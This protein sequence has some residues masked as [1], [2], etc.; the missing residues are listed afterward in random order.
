MFSNS[1]WFN[2]DPGPNP[3]FWKKVDP[4]TGMRTK[5]GTSR[6][7]CANKSL[8]L[9]LPFS[10]FPSADGWKKRLALQKHKKSKKNRLARIKKRKWMRI[11]ST[12]LSLK[13]ALNNQYESIPPMRFERFRLECWPGLDVSLTGGSC[14]R[15]TMSLLFTSAPGTQNFN[16][17]VIV[18]YKPTVLVVIN[19]LL[20]YF[21]EKT[22]L[23][24]RFNPNL[25]N[26]LEEFREKLDFFAL[27]F[28]QNVIF[29]KNRY[30]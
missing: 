10:R 2:S 14:C 25:G 27:P 19:G 11:G 21:G 6:K 26:V 9:H 22:L 7:Y 24:V 20:M 12:G 5:H 1:H 29:K 8:W 18:G 30:T 4:D 17:M 3:A 23:E 16:Y 28:P 13:T 15:H